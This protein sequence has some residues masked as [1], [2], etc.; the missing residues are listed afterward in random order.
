MQP[1]FDAI[2]KSALT[3]CSGM[4]ANAFRYD[5]ELLHFMANETATEGLALHGPDSKEIRL[6]VLEAMKAKYPMRPD[7][8]QIRNNFV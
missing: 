6:K 4:Y 1:V 7:P 3:L 2:V 8:S 5:G